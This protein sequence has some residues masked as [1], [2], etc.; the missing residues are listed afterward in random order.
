MLWRKGMKNLENNE[1]SPVNS[2][3]NSFS[4]QIQCLLFVRLFSRYWGYHMKHDK[5]LSSC[6]LQCTQVVNTKTYKGIR[7]LQ[8]VISAL[9]K[10]KQSNRVGNNMWWEENYC[11]LL[12]GL[13]GEAHS[14]EVSLMPK[15]EWKNKEDVLLS[16]KRESTK[17][18][19]WEEP[20]LLQQFKVS[21]VGTESVWRT[22]AG[23]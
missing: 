1:N 18:L 5:S 20:N 22:M 13:V 7:R 2:Y 14:G 4:H 16:E 8:M 12:E 19:R 3:I 10:I 6:S 9:N 21:D 23:Q 11:I 15:Q 17:L